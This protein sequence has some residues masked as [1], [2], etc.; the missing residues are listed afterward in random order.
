MYRADCSGTRG[1]AVID[2]LPGHPTLRASDWRSISRPQRRLDLVVRNALRDLV[3]AERFLE[4]VQRRA[5]S[6]AGVIGSIGR[7]PR[8]GSRNASSIQRAIRYVECDRP[9]PLTGRSR[10][11]GQCAAIYSGASCRSR[12]A[13]VRTAHGFMPSA[14]SWC[15]SS[16]RRRAVT[17]GAPG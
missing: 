5:R 13:C 2:K 1:L 14:I 10:F 15:A 7:M 3:D 11:H 12:L 6:P 4:H 8:S 17:G 9:L 16:C